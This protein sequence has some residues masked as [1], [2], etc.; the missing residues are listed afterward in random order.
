VVDFYLPDGT[1]TN[2]FTGEQKS[3]GRWYRETHDF[4]SLPLYV[5]E[6]SVL[7]LS[8][9]LTRPD[10]DW[11]EGLT[12][13]A[14]GLK[15]GQSATITVPN[16]DGTPAFTAT[17]TL[18]EGELVL[19]GFAGKVVCKPAQA[20][21]TWEFSCCICK[22]G[23]PVRSPQNH[24]LDPCGLILVSH[25]HK[26]GKDQKEQTFFCH[27][28]CFR[29]LLNDDALLSIQ[30]PDVQTHGEFAEAMRNEPEIHSGRGLI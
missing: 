26:D 13:H 8:A 12:L 24:S 1:W 6:G 16:P 19:H 20:P 21:D 30:D 9:D 7:A 17:L 4:F 14:Y 15:D 29:K 18:E 25:I 11:Q 27:F 3:G 10:G 22:E 28:E 2:F 5:R 23:V